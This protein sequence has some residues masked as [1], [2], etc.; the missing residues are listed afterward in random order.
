MTR[1]KVKSRDKEIEQIAKSVAL[2]AT[3]FKEVADMVIDQ[4][5]LI[6]RIDYN[7]EQVLLTSNSAR[8]YL[9]VLKLTLP[10]VLLVQVVCR[11]RSGLK[12]LHRA[13]RY[14]RNTRPERCILI[15]VTLIFICFLILLAKHA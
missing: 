2:L 9:S 12:E 13:E 6:D 15:L 5:T 1:F 14:Q 10:L 4:G 8:A 3:V 7:M 11:M